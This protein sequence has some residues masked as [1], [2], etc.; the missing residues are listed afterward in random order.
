MEHTYGDEIHTE[1]GQAQAE[2]P[3]QPGA[4]GNDLFVIHKQLRQHAGAGKV[5]DRHSTQ[6]GEGDFEGEDKGVLHPADVAA[7]VVVA[8]KGHDA[9]GKAH[10]DVHGHLVDLIGDAHGRY[11]IRP[12][13]RS[14]VVEHCHAGHVQQ[15]LDSGRDTDGEHAQDDGLAQGEHLGTDAHISAL[16]AA[17]EQHKEITASRTVGKESGQARPFGAHVQA[18]RQHK[19]GV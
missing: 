15:V 13:T 5:D 17:V 1:E 14:E 12:I 2:A 9:L 10:G 4:I 7:G 3:Q 11:G 6:E 8:D 16:A 19:D 18:P